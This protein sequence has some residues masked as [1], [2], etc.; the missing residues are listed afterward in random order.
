MKTEC[1]K[2]NYHFG[3]I[4]NSLRTNAKV[5]LVTESGM[6][7]LIMRGHKE[8]AKRFQNWVVGEVLPSLREKGTYTIPGADQP[9][10]FDV[11]SQESQLTQGQINFALSI[12]NCNGAS[13]YISENF[14]AGTDLQ[15][16]SAMLS[17]IIESVN[18]I[19]Q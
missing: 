16:V 12:K 15:K 13:I 19:W 9:K 2:E 18:N 11:H 10:L 17:N 4:L 3:S 5:I 6:Y 14:S 8:E 7:R 1:T